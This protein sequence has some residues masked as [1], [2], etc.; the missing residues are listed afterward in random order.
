MIQFNNAVQFYPVVESTIAAGES[1]T[2]AVDVETDKMAGSFTD[3]VTINTNV[4]A[5]EKLE[6]PV[7]LTV[8]GVAKPVFPTDTI[9]EEHVA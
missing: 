9:V 8:L 5:S 7:N 6:I 1:K 4:P 2:V 3:V